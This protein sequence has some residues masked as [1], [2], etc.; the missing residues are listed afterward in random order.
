M[1]E[2]GEFEIIEVN[3]SSINDVFS[4][5]Q[6]CASDL[7]ENQ[8]KTHWQDYYTSPDTLLN[9]FKNG[10]VFVMYLDGKPVATVSLVRNAPDYYYDN[11]D[12]EDGSSVDYRQIF[13]EPQSDKAIYR[14]ALGVLPAYQ[15][16]KLGK[17]MIQMTEEFARQSGY[18]YVRFD[19]RNEHLLESYIRQGYVVKGK[20]Y[21]GDVIY[22]LVEKHL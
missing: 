5:I 10:H 14:G 13:D 9:K 4:I 21:D 12:G 17:R 3:T 1:I 7:A 11:T 16:N 20:M 15:G 8:G 2:Q 19:T 6:A 18:E 22:Y